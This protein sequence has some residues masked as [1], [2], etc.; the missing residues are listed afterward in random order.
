ML[1]LPQV[2]SREN[3]MTILAIYLTLTIPTIIVACRLINTVPEYDD[4]EQP[5]VI[6]VAM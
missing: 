2:H 4:N 1:S 3:I 5:V 6:T